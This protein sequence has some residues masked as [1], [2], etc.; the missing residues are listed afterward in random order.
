M[1]KA[2]VLTWY[3]REVPVPGA[4]GALRDLAS[5]HNQRKIV[6]GPVGAHERKWP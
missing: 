6:S 5:G 4:G 3:G 2:V 1:P